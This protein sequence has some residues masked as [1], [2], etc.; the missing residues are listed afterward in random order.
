MNDL[1]TH[2]DFD[3]VSL[4]PDLF[5]PGTLR[6]FLFD[7]EIGTVTESKGMYLAI[8]YGIKQGTG[9]YSQEGAIKHLLEVRNKSIAKK[10]VLTIAQN[11]TS[12]F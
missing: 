3:K 11:Q 2:P 8:P 9:S 12:L 7:E 6:A 4:S 1:N 10:Q 5:N